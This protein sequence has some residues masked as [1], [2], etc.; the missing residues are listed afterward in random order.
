MAELRSDIASRLRCTAKTSSF[1]ACRR[2]PNLG[3]G[4]TCQRYVM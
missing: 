1:S 4:A 3:S 2:K